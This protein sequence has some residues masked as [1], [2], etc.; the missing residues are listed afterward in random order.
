[1]DLTESVRRAAAGDRN[2]FGELVQRYERL[3]LG[4]AWNSLRDY[5]AA[6][7]VAQDAFLIAYRQLGSLKEPAAFGAWVAQ[8]AIRCSRQY[9]KDRPVASHATIRDRVDEP[10]DSLIISEETDRILTAIQALP[11]HEQNVVFLRY[12]DG[13]DVATIAKLTDRPVGTVTKQLSRAVQ[14]L[15][16]LLVEV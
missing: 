11:E 3:V 6:Q 10:P 14:R 4:T 1:M 5:Q 7:D 15:K 13:Y 2:A 16:E 8:I 12:I 9:R